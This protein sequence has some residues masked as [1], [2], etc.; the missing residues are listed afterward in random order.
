[1][2]PLEDANGREQFNP[3]LFHMD[4]TLLCLSP[5]IDFSVPLNKSLVAHQSAWNMPSHLY[6]L[7]TVL[8]FAWLVSVA[9][10]ILVISIFYLSHLL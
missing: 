4:I 9:Y 1:M 7:I 2:H 10:L 6:T 5:M 8:C 3:Y